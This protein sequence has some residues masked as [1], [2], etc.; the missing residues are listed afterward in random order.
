MRT[1]STRNKELIRQCI[2]GLATVIVLVSTNKWPAYSYLIWFVFLSAIAILFFVD[3]RKPVNYKSIII[4]RDV[5]EYTAFG[6]K[7]IVRLVDITTLEFVREEA[8]FPDLYGPY[9]ESKWVVQTNSG[10]R[11][12]IMDEWPHRRKLLRV[13]AEYL[14]EFDHDGARSGL[15]ASGEGRWLCFQSHAG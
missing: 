5:I 2:I 3:L 4:L 15:K 9:I 10:R 1:L 8:I 6:K 13:F 7:E 12:E 14:P 11:V